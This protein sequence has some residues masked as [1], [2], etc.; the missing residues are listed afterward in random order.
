MALPTATFTPADLQ[1]IN[2][3][4]L[5]LQA[6]VLSE[7]STCDGTQLQ[8]EVWKG[9]LPVNNYSLLL[10]P[11]Q[12]RPSAQAWRIWRRF[13]TQAL[14]PG[15]YTCYSTHLPLKQPLGDWFSDFQRDRQWQWFY[16][17]RSTTFLRHDR[18]AKSYQG[19]PA[20]TN[21]HRIVADIDPEFCR[22]DLPDDAVPCDPRIRDDVVSISVHTSFPSPS[23]PPQPVVQQSCP[24]T[25]QILPHPNQP[26][27][28][29]VPS[30]PT[31]WS[32]SYQQLAEW[33]AALLPATLNPSL[34]DF[35]NH[36]HQQQATIFHCSD[37]SSSG[38]L[39]SFG[40]TF[41]PNATI[42]LKHSGP[43]FGLPMDSYLAEG[44]GLLSSSCF[45]YRLTK[46]VL[47][48][49]RP[50]FKIRMYCD[51]KSLVR[52]VNEF[53][54]MDGSFRRSLAPNYDVVFLTACVLAQFPPETIQVQ[55]V[56]GHQD[57]LAPLHKLSWPAQLN[58]AADREAS[59]FLRTLEHSLPT[60]FL[61]SAQI[62]LRDTQQ[63][64]I[65][66]KWNIYLRS[67]FHQHQYQAWLC[68]QFGWPPST[69][70][71]VDFEGLD[72]AIRC[73][74]THLHRFVVKWINQNLP[75]RRR[76]HRYDRHI[77][78]TCQVCPTIIECDNHLLHCP[79]APRRAAC[80]DAYTHLEERLSTL[81]THPGLQRTVLQLVALAM[82]IPTC[83]P[84]PSQLPA[85]SHQILLGPTQFLKG[86][87]SR[88]F[89]QTQEQFYR[90]QHRP[91]TFTGDKWMK[92][93]LCSLFEQLDN[94]WQCR[95]TQTHG[96]DQQ[97]QDQLKKAQLT[98]RVQALYNPRS[99]L[100]AHDRDLLD[101]VNQDDLLS[102]PLATI[103]TWL[104]MA[105]PTIQRCLKDARTKLHTNQSDIRDYFDDASYVD[106]DANDTT[107]SC[108]STLDSSG[109]ILF[110]SS[111][112]STSSSDTTGCSYSSTS[113]T[114][115]SGS[116][117]SP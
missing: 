109:T 41:G 47:H 90:A 56:K 3:C 97:L 8:K 88:T 26:P 102:G 101:T 59:Q 19:H 113:G 31:N 94:V 65:I 50:R 15:K 79:S 58:V 86:R 45:W 57:A 70:D 55:H 44:Y 63:N 96:A 73:L 111:S 116:E 71:D 66:K 38:N 112:H 24:Y 106:S 27:S 81:H 14:R 89:R 61:P 35:I 2:R 12:P 11:R 91:P 87:L 104:K 36:A 30:T 60:P 107:L 77:P 78:P 23:P 92:Q 43:A 46:L 74:P 28:V 7:I 49:R 95:N 117:G 34:F 83:S 85:Y 67:V 76:V 69:L 21:Q 80:G 114:P 115:Y 54:C 99:Q 6:N 33:E 98:I 29:P 64:I 37:G 105:E 39:G 48:R 9:Q 93:I 5:F 52:R 10:W 13:L 72:L 20:Q 82:A 22:Y 25:D 42:I 51:N 108:D 40:W 18:M 4:R 84:P 68:K 1:R 53:I 16:S 32:T 62:H 110:S 103:E 17:P 75:T 100:L